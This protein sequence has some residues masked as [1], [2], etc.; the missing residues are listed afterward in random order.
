MALV[1]RRRVP[2]D[3]KSNVLAC[4]ADGAD[5]AVTLAGGVAVAGGDGGGAVPDARVSFAARGAVGAVGNTAWAGGTGDTRF[6]TGGGIAEGGLFAGAAADG[7]GTGA[8]A[9]VEPTGAVGAGDGA[10][11]IAA[12]GADVDELFSPEHAVTA[13]HVAA[14]AQCTTDPRHSIRCR[15]AR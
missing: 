2:S 15:S 14:I 9:E 8:G 6:A 10:A 1:S 4:G 12:P 3:V 5:G 7:T 13:K 11:G